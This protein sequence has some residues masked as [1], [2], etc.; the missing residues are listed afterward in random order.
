MGEMIQ[1]RIDDFEAKRDPLSRFP[2]DIREQYELQEAMKREY[3][4]RLNFWEQLF[5]KLVE[6]LER[7]R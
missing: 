6:D 5:A 4:K 7:R 3:Y 2:K 1:T